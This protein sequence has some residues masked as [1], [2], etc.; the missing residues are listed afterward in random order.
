MDLGSVKFTSNPYAVVATA[1]SVS[2]EFFYDHYN[3]SITGINAGII[4]RGAPAPSLQLGLG[5][6]VEKFDL[7]LN[8]QLLS[9]DAPDLPKV[10][11]AAE[12][13]NMHLNVTRDKIVR[14]LAILKSLAS[15]AAPAVPVP[16]AAHQS[17]RASTTRKSTLSGWNASA[18]RAVSTVIPVAQARASVLAEQS[19]SE[20]SS[21]PRTV[22]QK[23]AFVKFQLKRLVVSLGLESAEADKGSQPLV[24]IHLINA[25]VSFGNSNVDMNAGVTLGGFEV[26][27]RM[28]PGSTKHRNQQYIVCSRTGEDDKQRLVVIEYV[29]I[30]KESSLYAK[31]DHRI[32]VQFDFLD[33]NVNRLS[34]ALLLQVVTSLSTPATTESSSSLVQLATP[35][36]ASAPQE[37][38]VLEKEAELAEARL[39]EQEHPPEFFDFTLAVIDA[40]IRGVTLNL[41]KDGSTFLSAELLG[42]TAHV[43]ARGDTTLFVNGSIQALTVTESGV[44]DPE[45]AKIVS[46]GGQK[47]LSFEYEMFSKSN[48]H[49]ALKYPGYD[50]AVNLRM[51]SIRGVFVSRLTKELGS[52]FGAFS[53]MREVTSAAASYY[54]TQSKQAVR[55]ASTA[56]KLH[57]DIAIANPYLVV[58]SSSTSLKERLVLDLGRISVKNKFEVVHPTRVVIDEMKVSVESFNLRTESAD[59]VIPIIGHTDVSVGLRRAVEHNEGHHVPDIELAVAISAISVSLSENQTAQLLNTLKGNIAD[60]PH[61]KDESEMAKISQ[62]IGGSSF[63]AASWREAQTKLETERALAKE[64]SQGPAFAAL[65]MKLRLAQVAFRLSE[66]AGTD[67]DGRQTGVVQL[68]MNEMQL[69]LDVMSDSA[70]QL[71]FR[72]REIVAEDIRSR[73]NNQF[74]RLLARPLSGDSVDDILTTEYSTTPATQRTDIKVSFNNPRI[75]LIPDPLAYTYKFSMALLNRS[76]KGLA[77]FQQLSKDGTEPAV[78]LP[79]AVPASSSSSSAVAPSSVVSAMVVTLVIKRPEIAVVEDATQAS[80][81][82]FVMQLGDSNVR[83]IQTGDGQQ[84]I[85]VHVEN[86]ELSKCVLS[87][88]GGLPADVTLLIQ[89]FSVAVNMGIRPSIDDDLSSPKRSRLAVELGHLHTILSFRDMRL[90]LS[91]YNSFTPL[92]AAFQPEDASQAALEAPKVEAQ[93]VSGEEEEQLDPADPAMNMIVSLKGLSFSMLDDKIDPAFSTPVLK[94]W[95]GGINCTIRTWPNSEM[96]ATSNLDAIKLDAY[97]ME[98]AAHEPVIEPWRIAVEFRQQRSFRSIHLEAEEM[99]DINFTKSL[100]DATLSG[101]ELLRDLTAEQKV[102]APDSAGSYRGNKDAE[103]RLSFTPYIVRNH[104]ARPIRYW[105]SGRADLGEGRVLGAGQEEPLLIRESRESVAEK[106]IAYEID[107]QIVDEAGKYQR[108]NAIPISKVQSVV[109]PVHADFRDVF[110][111]AAIENQN[112]SKIVTLRSDH[113]VVNDTSMELEL[114]VLSERNAAVEVA[115]PLVAPHATVAIPI[116]CSDFSSLKVRAK[117]YQ[118]FFRIARNEKSGVVTCSADPRN[119]QESGSWIC[120]FKSKTTESADGNLDTAISFHPSVIVENMLPTGISLRLLESTNVVFQKEFIPKASDLEFYDSS[121]PIRISDLLLSFQ[122]AGFAWSKPAPWAKK[123]G[124]D[125][126][127][128]SA[129][130]AAGRKLKFSVD[131]KRSDHGTLI[132]SIFSPYIIINQSCLRLAYKK[133]PGDKAIAAGQSATEENRSVLPADQTKWYSFDNQSET[134]QELV[135]SVDHGYAKNRFLYGEKTLS[136]RVENS[137]WSKDF[138]LGVQNQGVIFIEDEKTSGRHYQFA[139]VVSAAPGRLWRSKIVRIFPHV[140]LVNKT[141]STLFWKQQLDK[142]SAPAADQQVRSDGQIPLHWPLTKAKK[143]ISVSLDE[144]RTADRT[145][146]DFVLPEFRLK[147]SAEMRWSPFFS[148]DSVDS[149]QVKLRRTGSASDSEIL[150]VSVRIVNG[151]TFVIFSDGRLHKEIRLCADYKIDNRSSVNISLAQKGVDAEVASQVQVNSHQTHKFCWDDP[152]AKEPEVI[153]SVADKSAELSLDVITAEIKPLKSKAGA[154]SF[155]VIADGPTKLLVIS[156]YASKDKGK[157]NLEES[158]IDASSAAVA[159]KVSMELNLSMKGI[160]VS[161]I[162]DKP[163]ELLCTRLGDLLTRR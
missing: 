133:A 38:L 69:S 82:S 156:D 50:M 88:A 145:L 62:I 139:V 28:F 55:A 63:N 76:L 87:A 125:P 116:D 104:L 149:F 35:A 130:D 11:L 5:D 2:E 32:S 65:R 13:P 160:G 161:I 119:E 140:T 80:S 89:P 131:V 34:I 26:V 54:Y 20:P 134:H 154:I 141:A 95:I 44:D 138:P 4:A 33:V 24:D 17:A 73:T 66:S 108:Q 36:I 10:K 135:A 41:N 59:G 72:L 142:K 49:A 118:T 101:L 163:Q 9:A 40:T 84:K 98:L 48:T 70:L 110:L 99:L 75:S 159:R 74:R 94:F 97:N 71:V 91:V 158:E 77:E 112:G 43:D 85:D 105:V 83:F 16:V 78:Q 127:R 56:V 15:H 31:V 115:L 79:E 27:D 92:L 45:L 30:P 18:A 46:I 120:T 96:I 107:V 3:V 144:D 12:L 68:A 157:Q 136:L 124:G 151:A 19:T 128:M 57:L 67:S 64:S 1:D 53:Q 114:S 86:F 39:E 22:V 58:P 152:F 117:G 106:T 121:K 103:L 126:V 129:A 42:T 162:D 113:T 137:A 148:L 52:Y 14:L 143:R 8:L 25:G 7:N 51:G 21:A 150:Q 155:E 37:Q 102:A 123:V 61:R 109:R 93:S 29:G 153:V 100:L 111:V 122:I 47:M 6:V 147:P 60:R 132:V 90:G 81:P 146:V 23:V